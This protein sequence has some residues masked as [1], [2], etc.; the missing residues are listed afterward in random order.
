MLGHRIFKETIYNPLLF[1]LVQSLYNTKKSFVY[2]DLLNLFG[3]QICFPVCRVLLMT[4]LAYDFF[5]FGLGER[6]TYDKLCFVVWIPIQYRFMICLKSVTFEVSYL[7]VLFTASLPVFMSPSE[8]INVV[9]V[10]LA[11]IVDNLG[12][13]KYIIT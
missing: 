10:D 13:A 5:S 1:S 6:L 7:K 2:Y 4:N 9:L 11:L 3:V 8:A 12:R